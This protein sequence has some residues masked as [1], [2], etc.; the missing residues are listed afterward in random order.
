MCKENKKWILGTEDALEI[1]QEFITFNEIS[2]EDVKQELY[3]TALSACAEIKTDRKDPAYYLAYR[4]HMKKLL[5]EKY[6]D[7]NAKQQELNDME[8]SVETRG[9]NIDDLIFFR[10]TCS[11]P[12]F[13]E[14]LHILY[15]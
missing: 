4:Q 5:N 11:D 2:D 1:A 7:L 6:C 8:I 10:C 9:V 12:R 14:M 3:L 13:F 15:R